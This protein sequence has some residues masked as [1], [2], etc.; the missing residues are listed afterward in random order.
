MTSAYA[1]GSMV[2]T[3]RCS[4]TSAGQ[5]SWVDTFVIWPAP[6]VQRRRRGRVGGVGL[7][8]LV[9]VREDLGVGDAAEGLGPAVERRDEVGGGALLPDQPVG[10]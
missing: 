4:F 9:R 2:P 1:A 8:D 6:G 10:T 3:L 7:H 5:T